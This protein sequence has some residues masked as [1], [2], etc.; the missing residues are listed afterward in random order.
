MTFCITQ[1]LLCYQD[2][3]FYLSLQSYELENGP[4]GTWQ[5]LCHQQFDQFLT[6]LP[7]I[8][9]DHGNLFLT[10]KLECIQSQEI[11]TEIQNEHGSTVH[12]VNAI[13]YLVYE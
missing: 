5:T 12:F 6:P 4:N 13:P 1:N 9:I 11:R 10:H 3:T 2:L 8:F 7:K